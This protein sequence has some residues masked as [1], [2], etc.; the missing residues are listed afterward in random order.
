M[1]SGFYL[2]VFRRFSATFTG[3]VIGG[4]VGFGGVGRV[5]DSTVDDN[6]TRVANIYV[7][8]TPTTLW[9]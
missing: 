6:F 1:A 2:I 9:Q 7:K 3:I 8:V 4:V 5:V